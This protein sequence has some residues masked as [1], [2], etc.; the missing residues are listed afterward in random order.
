MSISTMLSSYSYLADLI[1]SAVTQF[2]EKYPNEEPFF[3]IKCYR[4]NK[5]SKADSD[6]DWRIRREDEKHQSYKEDLNVKKVYVTRETVKQTKVRKVRVEHEGTEFDVKQ[7]KILR[8]YEEILDVE[9]VT[10]TTEPENISY[11]LTFID[12]EPYP[13]ESILMSQ[14][15]IRHNVG[16]YWSNQKEDSALIA[17]NDPKELQLIKE[18]N[19]DM[20]HQ[21]ATRST[22]VI[23]M[24]DI[25][26]VSRY[27]K[28]I[29]ELSVNE[30]AIR[31]LDNQEKLNK[32]SKKIR[33][34]MIDLVVDW[35][36][37]KKE[38]GLI[39]GIT[40]ALHEIHDKFID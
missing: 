39:N 15:I 8:K 25:I 16:K 6:P 13:I 37:I 29:H 27:P 21:I 36:D 30:V 31:Y 23:K 22:S 28:E 34:L 35:D 40:E 32:M 19:L 24:K 4:K 20:A 17:I 9:T 18:G 26:D 7:S 5:I 2:K 14:Q 33:P 12:H 1:V 3:M 38:H 10:R 11:N